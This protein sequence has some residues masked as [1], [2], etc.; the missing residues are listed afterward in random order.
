MRGVSPREALD[1][2]A[3]AVPESC[4]ANIV[5]IGS[6]AAGYVY[7]GQD[8]QMAVRTKDIDCLLKP[9]RLA[10]R[11]GQDIARQLLDAGW[12]PKRDGDFSEPGTQQT[13]DDDLPAIR[14]YPPRVDP[15]NS[16]A[17]F[18]ELLTE[19]EST[20]SQGRSFTRVIL[21]EGHYGLPS[22]RFLALTGFMPVAIDHLGIFHARPAMM[23][24]ANLLEHRALRPD[25]IKGGF[26][27]RAIKRCNKDLGRVLAL[28]Y[29]NE[30]HHPGSLRAWSADWY[31]ALKQCFPNE[32]DDLALAR[33]VGNGLR[34]LM[35]SDGD[36]DEAFHACAY[37]LLAGL[38]V[39]KSTLRETGDRI[40]G[41]AVERLEA[42]PNARKSDGQQPLG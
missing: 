1:R 3:K 11:K 31:L 20:N 17:W 35:A 38:P 10:A 16:N 22:F 25:T 39:D 26:E 42:L 18:I 24:L 37:G 29:L 8:N 23:A 19:P 12:H 33:Q 5:V 27:G 13:P 21:D 7:F 28:G 9:H 2:I 6:L 4:R 14:L 36:F 41:D 40:L 34:A 30:Y 15:S 32:S